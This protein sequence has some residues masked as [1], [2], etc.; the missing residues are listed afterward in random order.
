LRLLAAIRSAS[1]GTQRRLESFVGQGGFA[2]PDGLEDL[3]ALTFQPDK[4][5]WNG[6]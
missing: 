1:A 2:H 3:V 6:E 5:P 4:L